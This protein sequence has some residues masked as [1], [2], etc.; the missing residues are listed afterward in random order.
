MANK[1]GF[2]TEVNNVGHTLN[3]THSQHLI[4]SRAEVMFF[5][6]MQRNSLLYPCWQG[7]YICEYLI[8][9]PFFEN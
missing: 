2:S 8:F 7:L 4:Y 9:L 3:I 1:Y 5:R 6:A